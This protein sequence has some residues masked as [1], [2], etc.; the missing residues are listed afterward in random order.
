MYRGCAV[1]MI[2]VAPE[3]ARYVRTEKF[4]FKMVKL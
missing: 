2:L 1:N 4:E 3:K